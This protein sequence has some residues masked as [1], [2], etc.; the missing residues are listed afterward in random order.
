[1]NRPR[2]PGQ[3]SGAVSIASNEARIAGAKGTVS[4]SGPS[5]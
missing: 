1:M 3:G 5:S 2:F 4:G